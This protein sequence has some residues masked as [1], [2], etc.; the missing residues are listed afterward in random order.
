MAKP[1]AFI[2]RLLVFIAGVAFYNAIIGVF[3][4]TTSIIALLLFVGIAIPVLRLSQPGEQ[5]N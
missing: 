4:V 1:V 2:N 3:G 5:R